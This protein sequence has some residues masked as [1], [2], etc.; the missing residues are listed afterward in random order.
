MT[1]H[2]GKTTSI[3]QV[4]EVA[5][6]LPPAHQQRHP[7]LGL[8]LLLLPVAEVSRVHDD[9]GRVVPT[10]RLEVDAA[11]VEAD[12]SGRSKVDRSQNFSLNFAA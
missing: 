1:L 11:V 2:N 7:R 8:A 9:V 5:L 6:L 12:Y 10:M 3:N 4:S